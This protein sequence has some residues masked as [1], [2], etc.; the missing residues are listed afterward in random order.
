M[1]LSGANIGFIDGIKA[2]DW[3]GSAAIV[4]MTVMFLLGIDFGG[5]YSPWSSPKI[6][7]LLVFGA[8]VST[9]FVFWE[10]KHAKF[11]LIPAQVVK[12]WHNVAALTICF[13]HG[14][15]TLQTFV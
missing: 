13:L 2:M 14:F 10:A 12:D 3:L 5:V 1:N 8:I 7:C 15:V 4:G 9:I 11:P 6:V